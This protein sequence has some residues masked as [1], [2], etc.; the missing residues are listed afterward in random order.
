MTEADATETDDGRRVPVED[1]RPTQ[2]YLSAAKLASVL[3]EFAAD[4]PGPLSAF[5]HED[6]WYLS[7]GHTRAFAA[8][9]GGAESVRIERDHE[10]REAYDFDLYLTCIDWCREENV[11]SVPDL[12]GRVLDHETFE[13]QWIE[14]C[15]RAA[16][17][18]E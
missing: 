16:G 3:E 8:Y 2:L 12:A 10:V 17:D 1:L 9:L 14:R 18:G 7:D 11:R 15:H 4:D 5:E 6:E 13:E